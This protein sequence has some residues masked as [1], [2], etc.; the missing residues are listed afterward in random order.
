MEMNSVDGLMREATARNIFPGARLLVA[1]AGRILLDKAYGQANIYSREAV[2]RTTLFDLASLTK[3]LATTLAL[4]KLIQKGKLQLDQTLAAILPDFAASSKGDIPIHRL[5]D[6]T[7][8]LPDYRPYYLEI[9]HL[10]V[11]RRKEALQHRIIAEPLVSVIGEKTRYSDI[12]FMIL[13]WVAE[14][15]SGI[16]LDDFVKTEIY[17]PLGV[18]NLFYIRHDRFIPAGKYAATEFCPWRQRMLAGQV[19]DDNA[20]VMG[21]VAGHAGLFGSA[22]AVHAV[23]EELLYNF[24][25]NPSK[26]V[27]SPDLVRLFFRKNP[28]GDRALGFDMPSAV[29]SSSGN[30]FT[31]DS[32]V[33]HLGFTG[34]SFW[35]DLDLQ[36]IV[37]LLTNRVHP[38]RANESI[39]VFRPLIHDQVMKE[40]C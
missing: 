3:P 19:H 31:L 20:Y 15:L 32:T 10:P 7:S 22:S 5:L 17:D 36:M 27:F 37:I 8:G 6:H 40:F 4:V 1:R 29:G 2:T 30:H 35:M 12:G 28:G 16:S 11:D 13:Q 9:R 38:S 33:G 23:L 39:K 34:T 25:G 26:R 21:G 14:G 18:E 24:H